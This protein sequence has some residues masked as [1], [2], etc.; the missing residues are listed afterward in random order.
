VLELGDARRHRAAQGL[1]QSHAEGLVG[2]ETARLFGLLEAIAASS[3]AHAPPLYQ[4]S[5][6]NQ[7]L[8]ECANGA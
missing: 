1:D 5:S 7:G 3:L 2:N 8:S 4:W 6:V